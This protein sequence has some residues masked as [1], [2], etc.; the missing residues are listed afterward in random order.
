MRKSLILIF[1]IVPLFSGCD[2]ITPQRTLRFAVPKSD[3]FYNLIASHLRP[4][5]TSNGYQIDVVGVA[6]GIEANR[7]VAQGDAELALS[8]NHS[9]IMARE[10]GAPSANLRTALP[11][12]SSILYVF[13][14]TPVT[15][16]T[17]AAELFGGRRIGIELLHGEA[18]ASLDRM[19][20]LSEITGY[21]FVEMNDNPDVIAYW[22]TFYGARAK[23]FMTEGWY[24]YSFRDNWLQFQVINEPAL[25]QI[26]LP[27]VPGNP[28]SKIL[29]TLTSDVLWV[30]NETVGE[31]AIYQ[32]TSLLMAKKLEL[33]HTDLMYRTISENIDRENLLYPLHEGTYAYLRR[34]EPTFLERYADAIALVLSLLAVVYGAFQAIAT[35]LARRKKEQ[36]D[37]Y[38]LDFMDIRS[39]FANEPEPQIAEL[40]TLF[41]RAVLQM[42]NEKI[43]KAD[44]HI[45][46]RLIQQ[47]IANLR[48]KH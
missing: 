11:L 34:D 14:R 1:L 37:R 31:N 5:L 7:L 18:H 39:K 8:F 30:T 32:L 41:Q 29:N 17:T 27:A 16:E 4:V 12:V 2:I 13:S 40:D 24:P 38:F 46:S 9:I 22:G 20:S 48:A 15:D 47:E 43:E 36:L 23:Q 28:K 44:F 25:K 10:L 3:Y 26:A 21:T 33:I 35:R 42:T 45:L 19:L 6:N